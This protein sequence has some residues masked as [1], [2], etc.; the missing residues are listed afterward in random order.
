MLINGMHACPEQFD[1]AS[2]DP[3]QLAMGALGNAWIKP[4]DAPHGHLIQMLLNMQHINT[5][6]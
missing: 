5:T 4:F 1:L 3:N 6:I 2:P